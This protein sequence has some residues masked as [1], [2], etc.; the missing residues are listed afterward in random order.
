MKRALDFLRGGLLGALFGSLVF[1]ALI[2]AGV[3]RGGS[4]WVF[5]AA[6]LGG[7][8]VGL[9]PKG[10]AAPEALGAAFAGVGGI[11]LGLVTGFGWLEV[12]LVVGAIGG[13]LWIW[14]GE[15]VPRE[16]WHWFAYGGVVIG[17]L[18]LILLPLILQ[19]GA[20]GHDESAYGLKAKQWLLGTPGTGW[21][22]HRGVGMSVY[23]Y[24]VLGLGEGEPGLRL[25]GLL[26]AVGL[27][28]GIW[29]L[30]RRMS[31]ATSAAMASVAIVAGPALLRRSTEYL[32]DVPAAA[33]LAWCMVVV[34]SQLGSRQRPTYRLLWVLP[35]ALAAFYL[36][37]QSILSL[38]LIALTIL[39]MWWPQIRRRPGPIVTLSALGLAGLIPH[40]ALAIRL[41]GSPWGILTYTSEVSGRAYLGEG[42]VDYFHM[43]P[44]QLAGLIFVPAIGFALIGLAYSW[45]D[46]SKRDRY[47]FLLLPAI[48]QILALGILSHG[49]PRFVFF[50]IA[51]IVAAAAIAIREVLWPHRSTIH[52]GWALMVLIAGS[53][54][55]SAAS[56]RNLVDHRASSNESIELAGLSVS[57]RAAGKSCG[58]MTSY[59]PQITYYSECSSDVFRPGLEPEAAVGNLVGE[60]KFMVLVEDGKRQPTRDELEGLLTLTEPDPVVIDVDVT[61]SLVYRFTE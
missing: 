2:T 33:L 51:L 12:S 18:L 6:T 58:V 34:W 60:M 21:A 50:P 54:A 46:G 16:R 42:L 13:V 9:I 10:S 41:R 28:V 1:A 5:V 47:L 3:S 59:T 39:V 20:L 11:V 52:F 27:V 36:R 35:P 8:V 57:D 25:L 19:G 23:G 45:K 37:Y 24:V 22:P 49:E 55:L 15:G 14:G 38:G 53:L 29:V 17:L 32:S 26:G 44:W 7:I 31:D 40:F 30:V 48:A 43:A 56:V 61:D 4:E